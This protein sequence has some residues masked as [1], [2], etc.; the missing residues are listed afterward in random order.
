MSEPRVA[1]DEPETP[2]PVLGRWR[3]FY[4]LLLIELGA[5]VVVFYLLTRWAA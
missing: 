5:L 1:H 2:P 3:N 4:A